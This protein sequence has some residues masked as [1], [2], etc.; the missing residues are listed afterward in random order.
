MGLLD[1]L[2]RLLDRDDGAI[3]SPSSGP[4]DDARGDD[5]AIDE[6]RGDGGGDGN[7]GG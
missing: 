7:G 2:R 1:W 3:T 5:D 4:E 6:S